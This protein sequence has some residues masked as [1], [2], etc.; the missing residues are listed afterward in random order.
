M[1]Y[2]NKKEEVLDIELTQ[3]GKHLL[4]IGKFNPTYYRFFD[5][6]VLYD[7]QYAGIEEIQNEIDPRIVN[8]TPHKKTQHNHVGLETQLNTNYNEKQK[9]FMIAE[10]EKVNMPPT[11]EREY[12]LNDPLGFSTMG[13]PIA[14]SLKMG[15]LKGQI[16][17]FSE[18]LSSEFQNLPIPQVEIDVI[19]KLQIRN[20]NIDGIGQT[21]QELASP[22]FDDDTFVAVYPDYLLGIFTEDGVPFEKENFNIEVYEIIDVSGSTGTILENELRQLSFA[23][24]PNPAIVNGILLDR[25]E[26][27]K[28][29]FDLT[30][31]HVE[32]FFDV[33]T[34]EEIS[35]GTIC[36]NIKRIKS[37]NFSLDK[38][39]NCPDLPFTN[40]ILDPYFSEVDLQKSTICKDEGG[41]Q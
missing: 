3:Y 35:E 1:T 14:P 24:I 22:I 29:S 33:L 20:L 19:Q 28:P 10:H 32:Y 12:V 27:Q 25:E 23:T 5:D 21:D 39:I 36:T 13:D 8:N 2:F 7:G 41:N 18:V 17:D 40:T 38:E 37:L 30:P 26:I 6:D 31:D 4:S 34:D 11:T 9:P 15:L 16:S